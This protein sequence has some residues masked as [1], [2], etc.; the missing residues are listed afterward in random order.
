VIDGA[1]RLT[2]QDILRVLYAPHKV[3]KDIIQKP[4][5]LI[6]I[7][8]LLVFVF[9]QIGTSYVIGSRSYI[10]QTV[11]VGTEGDVW[12]ENAAL[13]NATSG[14]AIS[15][16]YVDYI[17]GTQAFAGF[18]D[19][20]GNSSVEF[21]VSN[22]SMLQMALGNLDGQVDCGVNGSKEVFFRVKIVSPDAKPENVT[23]TLYSG[24]DT[25]F[26]SY[27]LTSAFSDSVVNVWNNIS[28]PVGSG[29]WSSS[30]SPSWES[31]TSLKLDFAW[32]SDSNIDLLLDGLFFRGKFITQI[33]L[34]G[35]AL[36]F[37][38]NS[39][40][41]GFAPFLFE[42]L[43][44]TGL[45]YVLIK[46]LKGNVIWKPL[47]A[48]VGYALVILVIQAVIITIVYTTLPDLNYTLE[49][50]AYVSGEFQGAYQVLFDKI[51]TVSTIGYIIQGAVWIWIVI[52]GTFITRAITSDKTIAEQLQT[53]K[54]AS[55]TAVSGEVEG[56][57]WMK[58]LL[59]AGASLFLTIIILGLLGVA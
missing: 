33:E 55:D 48:A 4:G 47:M 44:L 59:V 12:T 51:A 10:E 35:G 14:V 23:L 28:V 42:W 8:L 1:E 13:W 20:Y 21:K 53:G 29:D 24:S 7:I 11:P 30:G 57:S 5:Y 34:V 39:A 31:I 22:S 49:V 36:P 40:I 41:N 18:P 16:N 9:A 56:F 19:Y 25:D 52:L 6:P 27:D 38:A 3:F 58:C 32:S 37:L 54:A 17:N 15:D 46:G 43:L 50:L 45:M 2:A 26:F